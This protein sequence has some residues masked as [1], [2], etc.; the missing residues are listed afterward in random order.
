M[1]SEIEN[2]CF[3]RI[4]INTKILERIRNTTDHS[5]AEENLETHNELFI[6]LTWLWV[7]RKKC[8]IH[9]YNLEGALTPPNCATAGYLF[10]AEKNQ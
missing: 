1:N 6:G 9:K 2:D 8:F 10:Q 5:E 7:I 3:F 4:L